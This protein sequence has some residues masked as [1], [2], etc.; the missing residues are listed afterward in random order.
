MMSRKTEI[1][2]S[3]MMSYAI[4]PEKLLVYHNTRPVID[5]ASCRESL[6]KLWV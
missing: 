1:V 6:T 5:V 2:V 4:V 3:E